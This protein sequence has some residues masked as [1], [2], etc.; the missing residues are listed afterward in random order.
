MLL[1][2]TAAVGVSAA[3]VL[4]LAIP[5]SVLPVTFDYRNQGA[6][7]QFH[8]AGGSLSVRL[9]FDSQPKDEFAAPSFGISVGSHSA[10]RTGV[11]AWH[12]YWPNYAQSLGTRGVYSASVPLAYLLILAMLPTGLLAFRNWRVSRR[13]R[14]LGLCRKCGYDLRASGDQCPECGTARQPPAPASKQ[15]GPLAL[16]S[17][18]VLVCL[19]GWLAAM[20]AALSWVSYSVRIGRETVGLRILDYTGYVYR[21]TPRLSGRVL[22]LQPG[23]QPQG[24]IPEGAVVV[25]GDGEYIFEDGSLAFGDVFFVGRGAA[26]TRLKIHLSVA[27]RVRISGVTID[28]DNDPLLDARRGGALQLDRCTITGYNSGAGGSYALTGEAALLVED[29]E[30]DGRK[31]RA[32]QSTGQ[33]GTAFR[34]SG[35][36]PICIRSSKFVDNREVAHGPVGVF[37][38][39][40]LSASRTAAV[41]PAHEHTF[42]RNCSPGFFIGAGRPFAVSSDDLIYV[43]AARDANRTGDPLADRMLKLLDSRDD[44]R[45]WLA[46]LRSEHAEVRA[47]ARKMLEARGLGK[48]LLDPFDIRAALAQIAENAPES[49]EL[50]LRILAS[51]DAGL[52]LLDESARAGSAEVAAEA[53]ELHEIL[54]IH[55]EISREALYSIFAREVDRPQ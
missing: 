39:C 17:R 44:P 23:V 42:I 1:R 4:V 20:V 41:T 26:R 36:V 7:F 52:P 53:R 38:D 54:T 27:Q 15:T 50:R 47:I 12:W 43:R 35:D 24:W 18:H 9:V 55:P 46:L 28:C 22:A 30:F 49:S 48:A 33:R 37:D 10:L 51:G 13:R 5:L 6:T 3:I 45:F 11:P 8:V 25:L 31:G 21:T 2:W 16:S 32:A 40:R 29:C 34:M 19:V 14:R